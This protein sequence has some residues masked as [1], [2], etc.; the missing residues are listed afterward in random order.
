MERQPRGG[1][2]FL[3]GALADG[4]SL[5]SA[6]WIPTFPQPPLSQPRLQA[7]LRQGRRRVRPKGENRFGGGTKSWWYVEGTKRNLPQSKYNINTQWTWGEIDKVPLM[8]QGQ[9]QTRLYHYWHKDVYQQ[10]K[11]G[12]R[13]LGVHTLSAWTRTR[14]G[15]VPVLPTFS[16]QIIYRNAYKHLRC[17]SFYSFH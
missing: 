17:R 11:R 4:P 14:P 8:W 13:A 1:S 5:L 12:Q 3:P 2:H 9:R 7:F 16:S 10:L 15:R 6:P